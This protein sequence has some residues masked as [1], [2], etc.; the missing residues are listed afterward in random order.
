MKLTIGKKLTFSFLGLAILVLVSGLVGIIVLNKVASSGDTVVRE[1]VPAQYSVMKA[2][3]AVEGLQKAIS[4]YVLSTSDLADKEKTIVS[5]L[6]ELDMWIAMLELGSSSDKF[7]KSKSYKVYQT[8]KLNIDVPKSSDDLLKIVSKVKKESTGLRKGSMELVKAHNDYLAYTFVT[9]G[10]TYDLP[11][12][13]LVMQQNI[14]TWYNS[15]ESV[16]VSVTRFEKNTD[17]VKG[18][19]G[20]WIKNYKLDDK[21]FNKMFKQL[22]KY[23]KKLLGNAEKINQQKEFEGKINY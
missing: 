15:L 8:L 5:L 22:G 12:Y 4:D 13:I 21:V 16:V 14:A 1:K 2:N 3:L 10:K 11:T 7:K 18:P 20:V 19:I 17:P 9:N 23:H 6:D